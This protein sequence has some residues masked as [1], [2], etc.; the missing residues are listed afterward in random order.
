MV[1]IST[2]S[3]LN[4][5]FDAPVHQ[6]FVNAHAENATNLLQNI[7]KMPPSAAAIPEPFSGNAARQ[8]MLANQPLR[9]LVLARA[10]QS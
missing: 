4:S 6:L 9:L 3:F 8:L 7:G 5:C 2:A 1:A 10:Y